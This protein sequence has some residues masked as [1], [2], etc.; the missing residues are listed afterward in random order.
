VSP[1]APTTWT[2]SACNRG[3][4]T[5]SDESVMESFAVHTGMSPRCET[6]APLVTPSKP[7]K[8]KRPRS[9]KTVGD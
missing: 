9:Y 6:G 3:G 1:T 8:P 7:T 2:C 4:V 5:F